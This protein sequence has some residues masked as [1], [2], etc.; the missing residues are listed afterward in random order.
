LKFLGE[1]W[2]GRHVLEPTN[3]STN[4]PINKP[5]NQP[6]NQPTT[7]A[8]SG[9]LHKKKFKKKGQADPGMS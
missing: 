3:Q 9:G 4:Q 6:T 5:T 2:A 7:C 8:K 1:L